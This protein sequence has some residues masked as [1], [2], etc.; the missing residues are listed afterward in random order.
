[1][2]N[3]LERIYK[4]AEERGELRKAK[5]VSLSLAKMGFPIE[6][7]AQAVKVSKETVVD[8]ISEKE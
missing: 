3:E 1:M 2:Y 4:E 5:E 8:W 7:I 6:K